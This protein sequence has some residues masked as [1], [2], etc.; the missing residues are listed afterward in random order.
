LTDNKKYKILKDKQ[1]IYAEDDPRIATGLKEIF[2]Y[3]FAEVRHVNNGKEA[4]ELFESGFGDVVITDV[5]MPEI[6]GMRLAHYFYE[7]QS[8]I[9]LVVISANSDFELVRKSIKYKVVDYIL[10]PVMKKEIHELLDGI[11]QRFQEQNM[12]IYN[13]TANIAYHR[14]KRAL[15][16][17]ENQFALGKLESE[18]LE[19][20]LQNRGRLL[21]KEKIYTEIYQDRE[22]GK[23]SLKNLIS[24]LRK[25]LGTNII[26]ALRDEGY[27]LL[28]EE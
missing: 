6:D 2:S 25:K 7:T 17:S 21:S 15:I 16:S 8:S 4:I 11:T 19:L 26:V 3:Y 9:P 5:M 12:Q 10:K 13:I 24:K 27:I 23:S 14:E 1:L 20:L 22:V 28:D 18:M